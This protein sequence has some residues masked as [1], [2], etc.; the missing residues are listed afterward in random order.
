MVPFMIIT[1]RPMETAILQSDAA[2]ERRTAT[3]HQ[4]FTMVETGARAGKK[5]VTL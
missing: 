4:D 2:T 5:V 3:M 1:R